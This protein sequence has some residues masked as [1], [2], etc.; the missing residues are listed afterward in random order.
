MSS[1][2]LVLPKNAKVAGKKNF[3]GTS[4][5]RNT[6]EY[7]VECGYFCKYIISLLTQCDSEKSI[8]IKG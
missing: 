6:L 7:K 2:Y 4:Q 3:G 1:K 8:D 5:T